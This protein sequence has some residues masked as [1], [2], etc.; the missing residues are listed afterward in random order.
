[1]PNAKA[2]PELRFHPQLEE[3]GQGAVHVE[4]P[5]SGRFYR[6]SPLEA[7]LLSGMNGQRDPA[8]LCELC[9][10]RGHAT[11]PGFVEG[12]V[13]Q[14][15]QLGLLEGSRAP[16]APR[17]DWLS[18]LLFLRFPLL[19]P[20]PWL[21]LPARIWA[22]VYS[23]TALLALLLLSVTADL[24]RAA[25]TAFLY[26]VPSGIPWLLMT[27]LLVKLLH[28]IGHAAAARRHGCQVREMGIALLLFMPCFY[29]NTSESWALPKRSQRFEIGVA[30]ILTELLV[31]TV[32]AFTWYSSEAGV[33]N[34]LAFFLMTVA[35][36][37]SVL[38]NGNPLL[39]FDG[40]FLLSDLLGIPNLAQKSFRRVSWLFWNR[41]L[42]LGDVADPATSRTEAR[43]LTAYGICATVYRFVLAVLIA[44]LVYVLFLPLLGLFLTLAVL[45]RFLLRPLFHTLCTLWQERSRLRPRAYPTIGAVVALGLGFLLVVLPLH[46]RR[47]YP[48][49]VEPA[50]VVPI[51]APTES[52]LAS[53]SIDAG[54]RVRRG[55]RLG[56]L[57]GRDLTQRLRTA[58]L[59]LAMAEKQLEDHE[60]K[61]GSRQLLPRLRQ[62]LEQRRDRCRLL[63]ED[64]ERLEI[65][66]PI[67]GLVVELRDGLDP[68]ARLERGARIGSLGG[69]LRISALVAQQDLEPLGAGQDV[70]VWIAGGLSLDG[71]V[72]EIDRY[73]VADLSRSALASTRGGTVPTRR[74]GRR[75]EPPLDPH[76]RV[77][78]ELP[79]FTP[80]L[81]LGV[82]GRLCVPA[83]HA[84]LLARLLSSGLSHLHREGVF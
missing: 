31:A 27:V 6:M 14:C 78:V 43:I 9:R 15:A 46:A 20:S 71:K 84:P 41:W 11:S 83:S 28:E 69:G 81:P 74:V 47:V 75:A 58:K 77:I 33:L 51:L 37:N 13:S 10:T 60:A 64:L 18:S 26:L 79:A 57:D 7:L 48:C 17:R 4:D 66:A 21:E 19:D 32:A 65:R 76:Y 38:V 5:V 22:R 63:G 54:D 80:P 53:W 82:T 68:G 67:D 62:E 1:M 61:E 39:R 2:R 44:Q 59:E 16:E 70:S 23:R 25:R 56:L 52:R 35:V 34:S 24:D 29:V 55:Q 50:D 36:L 8:A 40:Y 45:W 3:R 30:G 72:L 12:L 42:G 49:V 73:A